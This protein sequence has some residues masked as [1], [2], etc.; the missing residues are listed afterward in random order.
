MSSRYST[1]AVILKTE[2]K[3]EYDL[4]CVCFTERFGK[5]RLL[6]KGAR[7]SAS[8]L[9]AALQPLSL[10]H[11]EFVQGKIWRVVDVMLQN[12]HEG[13]RSDAKNL[14]SALAIAALCRR[15]TEEQ[16]EVLWKH[17]LEA[18]DILNASE[19]R[20]FM[21]FLVYYHF[22]WNLLSRCGYASAP[23][24]LAASLLTEPL[25]K[26]RTLILGTQEQ[27]ELSRVSRTYLERAIALTS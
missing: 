1:L 24:S 6:A 20:P 23:P 12:R 17:L 22:L 15:F 26:I 16:D 9:R 21:P 19:E 2:A 25:W 10:S 14:R 4:W 3:G 7:K 27:K 13:L 8:K 5:M 18:L 11:I